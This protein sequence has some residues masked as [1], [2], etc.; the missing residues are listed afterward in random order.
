MGTDSV[1]KLGDG[2]VAPA[3]AQLA[4]NGEIAPA[5]Q[6][7]LIGN[8]NTIRPEQVRFAVRG[9][10]SAIQNS[11]VD[12]W[13]G[14]T[15]L[16][17]FPTVAQQMRIVSSS[18]NDAAAGTG[19][20][21]VQISYLDD[22]YRT[23][24]EIV[25]LNGTTPVNTQATNILRINSMHAVAV[26]ST[27]LSAGNI[28]LQAI[29]GDTTFA[30]MFAGENTA[31][32]AVFTIPAGMQGYISHWQTSSGSANNH[33]CQ[34]TLIATC[35]E[36]QPW[37]GVMLAQDEQGTQ[38]GGAS[39]TLPIPIPVPEKTDIAIRCVSDAGNANV[40]G[41]GSIFGWYEPTL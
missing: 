22:E 35:H 36:N 4:S 3:Y 8:Q 40:T 15:A 11:R 16:Y 25:A 14:P 38:N 31:R 28:S 13:G 17:V 5:F 21:R 7:D 37:F 12:L 18:A 19:V 10:N 41:L 20:Q 34:M 33:F 23:Q 27:T 32:Q 26:G 30:Y 2:T 24:S 1:R 39:I 9:K 29:G 6:Q